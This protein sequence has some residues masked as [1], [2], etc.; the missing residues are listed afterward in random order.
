MTTI[1]H[2]ETK[3]TNHLFQT[4]NMKETDQVLQWKLE[5]NQGKTVIR[6]FRVTI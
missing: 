2:M 4:P 6:N 3:E 5:R 1:F